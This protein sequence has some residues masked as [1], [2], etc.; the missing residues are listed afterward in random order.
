MPS[1][2]ATDCAVVALSPV[3]ITMRRPAAC[4]AW[5]AAGVS[6]LMRSATASSA[7]RLPSTARN[8]TVAPFA[9]SCSARVWASSPMA[10]CS[11]AIS[12]ALPNAAASRSTVAL[13]PRPVSE[14]NSVAASFGTPSASA[15]I[16]IAR[17]SGCSLGR[18]S[19]A[20][21]ASRR[22][23]DWLP[24]IT[25]SVSAGLPSVSVPV[26]STT[27]VSMS[28]SD[29]IAPASLNNTPCCAPRP[30]ATMIEIGVA[31]P[32]AHGQAM[33]STDTAA[34][35]ACVSRGSGPTIA[36]AANASNATTTTA[37]TNH[38]AT[39]S[40]TR[41]SGARLRWAA[42]T[43]AT[44]CA[45]MVSPPTFCARMVS[46]PSWFTVPPVTASSFALTTGIGSP[47]SIDSSTWLWPSITTPSTGT[48]SPG[49]TRSTSPACTSSSGT[50]ASLPSLAIRRA[51]FGASP[52]SAL[53]AAPVRRRARSSRKSPSVTRVTITAADSK[54]TATRPCMSRKPSGK[55]PGHRNATALYSHATPV[56]SAISVYM[57]GRQGFSER[58]PRTKNGAPPHSTTMLPSTASPQAATPPH[59]A[60]SC[61]PNRCGPIATSS[62]G[63]VSATSHQK[64]RVIERKSLSS[65]SSS[66]GIIGSSA[67]PQIGQW[68]GPTCCTSGCIGQV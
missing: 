47:V 50:S 44:I 8:I 12:L 9:R 11:S 67:M 40:A 13:T 3:S 38:A 33:I 52:S 45:S 51:V 59:G 31:R 57:F 53:S 61:Q 35:S 42:A 48:F 65:S 28:R 5:M 46:A 60:G 36:H 6:G 25:S 10:T 26:L 39:L 17:A 22:S 20:A 34:I 37:G 63:R 66:E 64:R 18:S 7:A 23:R 21:S 56:P 49:R 58:Q 27:R 43:R 2:R 19:A 41:C 30:L 14:R 24:R 4:S 55:I 62:T 16:T 54:Y 32:S 29:S 1:V 68:P 15:A